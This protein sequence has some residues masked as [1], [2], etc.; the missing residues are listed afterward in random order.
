MHYTKI[1][2]LHI[3]TNLNVA[4]NSP[5][6]EFEDA[7]YHCQSG[8]AIQYSAAT[9]FKLACGIGGTYSETPSWDI[10]YPLCTSHLPETETETESATESETESATETSTSIPEDTNMEPIGESYDS[11][12]RKRALVKYQSQCEVIKVMP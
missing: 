4:T 10:C 7:I 3:D 8:Y 1:Y 2:P 5:T 11:F 6:L 9:E 12:G